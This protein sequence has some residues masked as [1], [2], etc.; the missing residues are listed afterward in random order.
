MQVTS[1]APPRQKMRDLCH[2]GY[3]FAINLSILT[4]TVTF[5]TYFLMRWLVLLMEGV[6]VW[7]IMYPAQ[8]I[9]QKMPYFSINFV[10]LIAIIDACD[11]DF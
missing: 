9:Y 2:G 10:R 4:T 1:F 11:G 5:F 7:Q 8:E 3:I 6:K